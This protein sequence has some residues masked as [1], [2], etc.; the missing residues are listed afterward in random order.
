MNVLIFGA[1][2]SAEGSVLRA[3]LSSSAVK[4]VRTMLLERG[5]K[6]L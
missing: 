4:E 6:V 3:C 5:A 2:G 1:S